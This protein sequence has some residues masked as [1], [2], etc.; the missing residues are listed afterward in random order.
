MAG[1]VVEV[2]STLVRIPSGECLVSA[3]L[4]PLP[5]TSLSLISSSTESSSLPTAPVTKHSL[6]PKLLNVPSIL[7][8]VVSRKSN[9][10]KNG[11]L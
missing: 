2:R 3:P 4:H 8:S 1:G 6:R 5:T 9:S 11:K 7:S 10:S